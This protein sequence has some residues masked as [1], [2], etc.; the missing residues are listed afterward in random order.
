MMIYNLFKRN[1]IYA[2][3]IKGVFIFNI[4]FVEFEN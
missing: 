1:S 3:N 2:D 4:K